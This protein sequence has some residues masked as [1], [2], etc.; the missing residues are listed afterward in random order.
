MDFVRL[1]TA[2][3]L[4][5]DIAV[6]PVLVHGAR[7]PRA[8]QLPA[9]LK[10]FAFRNAVELT[11]A[12][13]ES[14]VQVLIKALQPY[15]PASAGADEAT[16]AVPPRAAAT[17][18]SRTPMIAATATL[19]IAAVGLAF[20]QFGGGG[21]QNGGA[22]QQEPQPSTTTTTTTANGTAKDLLAALKRAK[23]GNSVGDARMLE[24]LEA[25]DLRYRRLA[26]AG[27]ALLGGRALSRGGAD[28]DK[29]NYFYVLGIGLPDGADLPLGHEVKPQVLTVALIDSYND[30]NGTQARTLRDIVQQD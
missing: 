21:S 30:K 22:S 6:V 1:E 17:V 24:W 7:M 25:P 14:D 20:W 28:L 16:S 10:E 4:R 18:G 26:E 5:R 15:A 2:S 11:H 12:R 9:D 29:L 8:E 27:L 3:A 23:L 19:V 13:W